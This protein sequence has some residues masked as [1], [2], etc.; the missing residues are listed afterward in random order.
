M[1]CYALEKKIPF[2]YQEDHIFIIFYLLRILISVKKNI[3]SVIINATY[4]KCSHCI[5]KHLCNSLLQFMLKFYFLCIFLHSNGHNMHFYKCWK[6]PIVDISATV[7]LAV[8]IRTMSC[9]CKNVSW[10]LRFVT[11]LRDKQL[12]WVLILVFGEWAC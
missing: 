2:A 10:V 6:P 12:W 9:Y 3:I 7:L 8:S 11:P 1:L 5:D 4:N